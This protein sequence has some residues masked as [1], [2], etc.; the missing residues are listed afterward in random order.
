M[1][2]MGIFSFFLFFFSIRGMDVDYDIERCD[3]R[4]ELIYEWK[5][6]RLVHACEQISSMVGQRLVE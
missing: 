5:R 4:R 6:L 2:R 1:A 3:T